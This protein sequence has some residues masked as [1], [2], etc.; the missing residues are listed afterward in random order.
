MPSSIS[1]DSEASAHETCSSAAM[2]FST[3]SAARHVARC[4]VG[5]TSSLRLDADMPPSAF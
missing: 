2:I 3:S 5:S 4:A 1:W